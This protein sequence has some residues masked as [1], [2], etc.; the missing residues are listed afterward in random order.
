MRWTSKTL[1]IEQSDPH[2]PLKRSIFSTGCADRIARSKKLGSK[3]HFFDCARIPD[4]VSDRK[5]PF[6]IHRSDCVRICTSTHCCF[7][8]NAVVHVYVPGTW[9]IPGST[10]TQQQ[11]HC[12]VSRTFNS[13][14]RITAHDHLLSER[15]ERAHR[16][17]DR[18]APQL[19]WALGVRSCKTNAWRPSAF[20]SATS[21]CA[22]A[23]ISTNTTA[24]QPPSSVL[25]LSPSPCVCRLVDKR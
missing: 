11:Q 14:F 2:M 16:E 9:Y 22:T 18:L 25:P 8:P 5:S 19:T 24:W 20:N 15:T 10:T 6:S 21:S 4:L 12:L 23:A 17:G 7:R 3:R 13:V 1:S